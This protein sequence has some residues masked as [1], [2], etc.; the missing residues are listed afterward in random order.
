M[1]TEQDNLCTGLLTTGPVCMFSSDCTRAALDALNCRQLH[2]RP[3]HQQ[4]ECLCC[5]SHGYHRSHADK[6]EFAAGAVCRGRLRLPDSAPRLTWRSHPAAASFPVQP[7]WF[8]SAS[9]VILRSAS[10]GY[11]HAKTDTASSCQPS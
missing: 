10:S 4:A 11:L 2:R 7:A 9:S 3:A 5:D 6:L 1:A 8:R